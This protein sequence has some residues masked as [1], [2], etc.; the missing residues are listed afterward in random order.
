MLGALH[1]SLRPCDDAV[2][3]RL[4]NCRR[5]PAIGSTPVSL[6]AY[7]SVA[8][9]EPTIRVFSSLPCAVKCKCSTH[10]L[11]PLPVCLP[12]PMLTC[13]SPCLPTYLPACQ[14][15]AHLEALAAL[16]SCAALYPQAQDSAATS[17]WRQLEVATWARELLA[18]C[19]SVVQEYLTGE[20]GGGEESGRGG[21]G[22]LMGPGD[23]ARRARQRVGR[24]ECAV[25]L[26]GHLA[27]VLAAGRG[28][29][30]NLEASRPARKKEG[31]PADAAGSRSDG[32]VGA[33]AEVV[34]ELAC[35]AGGVKT[36]GSAREETAGAGTGTGAAAVP[37]DAGNVD[38]L[39]VGSGEEHATEGEAGGDG[40]ADG[41]G[42]A[43]FGTQA[44]VCNSE[45]VG[46]KALARTIEM[47]GGSK[48]GGRQQKQRREGAVLL[49]HAWLAVGKFCLVDFE[50]AKQCV[51]LLVQVGVR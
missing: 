25:Y 3:W 19:T 32:V 4:Q 47:Q 46:G 15:G 34:L 31:L 39:A 26:C 44:S 43:V 45:G 22:R 10:H 49:A 13:T 48:Q 28:D 51:P 11:A 12:T 1:W 7:L 35:Q 5:G 30:S 41:D 40:G 27:L 18:T 6:P 16:C 17:A 38:R 2:P 36:G 24:A 21:D 50:L 23:G 8:R 33:A 37:G 14:A 42:D 29:G 9:L 20:G